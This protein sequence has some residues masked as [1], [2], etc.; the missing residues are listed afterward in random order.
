MHCTAAASASTWRFPATCTCWMAATWQLT[1]PS[2]VSN[3][4]MTPQLHVAHCNCTYSTQHELKSRK[5]TCHYVAGCHF[6]SLLSLIGCWALQTQQQCDA[7]AWSCDLSTFVSCLSCT[8]S[9]GLLYFLPLSRTGQSS[10]DKIT[11]N[12]CPQHTRTSH[13]KSPAVACRQMCA[14]TGPARKQHSRAAAHC[15]QTAAQLQT[16]C[17]RLLLQSA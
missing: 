8:S 2:Q 11:Y 16:G 4:D 9:A 15:M 3:A 7:T 14:D 17:V 5:G 13:A 1:S 6:Q 12:A 10:K